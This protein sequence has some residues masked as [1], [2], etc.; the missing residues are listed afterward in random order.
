MPSMDMLST[1][2]LALT[3]GLTTSYNA[4]APESPNDGDDL[5]LPGLDHTP[6]AKSNGGC[7]PPASSNGTVS[8]PLSATIQMPAI[9]QAYLQRNGEQ[10]SAAKRIF[11]PAK[12]YSISQVLDIATKELEMSDAGQVARVIFNT[13]GQPVTHVDQ[14]GDGMNMIISAGEPFANPKGTPSASV[15]VDNSI[16]ADTPTDRG[17]F[18]YQVPLENGPTPT[19]TDSSSRPPSARPPSAS[20]GERTSTASGMRRSSFT[21]PKTTKVM[22]FVNQDP[23]PV[24]KP[25]TI[26]V[27]F[28]TVEQLIDHVTEVLKLKDSFRVAKKLYTRSGTRINDFSVIKDDMEIVVSCGEKF[29]PRTGCGNTPEAS[30][31]VVASAASTDG[32]R[33]Q[34]FMSNSQRTI[35]VF[36]NGDYSAN[37]GKRVVIPHNFFDLSQVFDLIQQELKL[38]QVGKAAKQLYMQG[39]GTKVTNLQQVLHGM[40]LVVCGPEKFIPA[41][42]TG[43]APSYTEVMPAEL[44][45]SDGA[46]MRHTKVNQK[47]VTVYINGDYADTQGKVV[48]IPH[49]FFDMKQLLDFVQEELRLN[50]MLHARAARELF[51]LEDGAPITD[52]SHIFS[53][54]HIAVGFGEKFNP[55]TASGSNPPRRESISDSQEAFSRV[56]PRDVERFRQVHQRKI[57]VFVNGDMSST[58][59][60]PVVV[61]HK[62]FN[63]KQLLDHVDEELKLSK[64]FKVATDLYEK[65]SGTL[66]TD[67]SQVTDEMQ[68]VVVCGANDKFNPRT[69]T[70]VKETATQQFLERAP[71]VYLEGVGPQETVTFFI[72]GDTADTKGK[73][74]VVPHKFFDIK[75]LIEL[76]D[77]TLK[78]KEQ[79]KAATEFFDRR[80]GQPVT[81]LSQ[82]QDGMKLVVTC[83]E[84]FNPQTGSGVVPK[85]SPRLTQPDGDRNLPAFM[86][87][88]QRKITAIYPGKVQRVKSIVIPRNF[89]T[90]EQVIDLVQTELKIA[91]DGKSV[92]ALKDENGQNISQLNQLQAGAKVIADTGR[93]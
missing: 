35:V 30:S 71:N 17:E 60:K 57:H 2:H 70:G 13:D 36:V 40:K 5:D 84:R 79:T 24:G 59:G 48:V 33:S 81:H 8:T 7:A 43:A 37:T 10:A 90:I 21:S 67:L 26:P 75:Q 63:L 55:N 93:V 38:V 47:K 87:A 77:E 31:S 6:A 32:S 25:C 73:V 12:L 41:T 39:E 88:Q 46:L 44:R 9:K 76:A 42:G 85:E 15:R 54:M 68:V 72:N 51:A 49:H 50:D 19:H 83:G 16:G 14:I 11:L 64:R 78:L 66:I 58:I 1:T 3:P 56:S 86:A 34:R 53:G 62:F 23:N 92:R 52:V 80:T 69:G 61:P 22:L 20:T 65:E 82:V 91:Q 4:P 89:T 45:T 28:F 27:K 29:D 18:G 74:V